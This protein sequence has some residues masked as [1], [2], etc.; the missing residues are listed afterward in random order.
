MANNSYTRRVWSRQCSP[1]RCL[2]HWLESQLRLAPVHACWSMAPLP[3]YSHPRLREFKP[4]YYIDTHYTLRDS[5][6]TRMG[7]HC[8]GPFEN[9]A[10]AR[11]NAGLNGARAKKRIVN[12]AE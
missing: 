9:P 10:W 11:G 12:C 7:T 2:V 6:K 5:D 3:V 1:F 4:D 8:T